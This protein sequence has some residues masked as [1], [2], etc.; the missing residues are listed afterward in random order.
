MSSRSKKICI[1]I[2]LALLIAM[3]VIILWVFVRPAQNH[4]A[5]DRTVYPVKGIDISGHNG[6]IDFH[7]VKSD[8][9]C[10]VYMKATEG[11]D[12]CDSNF[13]CNYDAARKAG[14]LTGAYH[15]F[16]FDTPG[17]IQAL[18]FLES[19]DGHTFDLPL[20]IDVEKW[21]NVHDYD[22]DSVKTEL[23]K[24][25]DVIKTSG[26]PVVIYTNKRGL[27]TFIGDDFPG[28]KLWI[29]SL[30]S[31]PQCK[32]SL[33]QHSHYNKVKGVAK[34]VDTNTFRGTK[35][36]FAQWLKPFTVMY[37][38]STSIYADDRHNN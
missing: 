37:P 19:V 36:E 20:A 15:F 5:V 26:Y 7:A 23:R 32:W 16:R 38:D 30:S 31:P 28:E 24:M 25:L 29:C 34:P 12:F 11:T 18:H 6:T 21:G 33:W 4:Y 13:K 14:L 3:V 35:G 9:V 27:R 17:E 10:F 1:F 2:D 8:T 22:I